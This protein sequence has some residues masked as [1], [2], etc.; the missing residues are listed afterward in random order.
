MVEVRPAPPGFTATP[1]DAATLKAPAPRPAQP[2]EEWSPTRII[3]AQGYVDASAQ[4]KEAWERAEE[5]R[6][7]WVGPGVR[8][9]SE[10]AAERT[11]REAAAEAERKAADPRGVLKAAHELRA[12]AQAEVERLEPLVARARELVAEITGR[13]HQHETAIEEGDAAAASRLIE[14]IASG[15]ARDALPLS[16]RTDAIESAAAQ[17]GTKLRIA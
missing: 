11:E 9:A 6:L 14:A 1:I 8:H 13:H 16:P 12:E 15:A 2:L 10:I 4:A 7:R 3:H 5:V 17:T